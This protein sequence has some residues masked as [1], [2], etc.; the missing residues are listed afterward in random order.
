KP[1]VQVY[2]GSP[3]IR[4]LR[5]LSILWGLRLMHVEAKTYEEGLQKTL[6][7]AIE[8][9]HVSYGELA[10]LTYGLRESRQH[11]E[12]LRVEL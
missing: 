9:N 1:R 11:I 10:V 6:E 2:V 7:K 3:D 4:V 8:L 5:K 12:I